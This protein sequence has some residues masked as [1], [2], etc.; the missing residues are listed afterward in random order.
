MALARRLALSALLVVMVAFPASAEAKLEF[1]LP[2]QIYKEFDESKRSDVDPGRCEAVVFVEFPKIKHAVGYRIVVRRNDLNGQ[3]VD[4][5]APPFDTYGR[6]FIARFPAPKGFARFFVGAYSSP[7]S[8]ADADART[9]GPKIAEATVSLDKRFE[10]RF[11]ELERPPYKCAY[12][13][14]TRTVDLG[15]GREPRKVVVRR[16]GQV[17]TIEKGSNQPVNLPTNRYAVAGTIVKTGKNSA[18][19]IGTLDG[20]SVIVGP[21]TT[22]RLTGK[23]LEVLE[24]PKHQ[25]AWT[26]KI[27]R[28]PWR[29]RTSCPGLAPSG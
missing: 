16:Q 19:S 11:R 9:E 2:A 26:Y 10:R 4:Y 13:P 28:R 23:G 15:G 6:G 22:V 29:I 7:D 24:A 1:N 21:E 25:K 20:K 12:K 18:V 27:E 17:A 5:V 14:G 8:C 3:L